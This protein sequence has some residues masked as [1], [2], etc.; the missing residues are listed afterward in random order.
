VILDTTHHSASDPD[1]RLARKSSQTACM[2]AYQA[3]VLVENRHGLVI[4]GMVGHPSGPTEIEQ[5]LV[6]LA[7]QPPRAG[8]TVGGDTE[9]DRRAFVETSRPLGFVSHVAQKRK[10]SSLDAR[11]VRHAAYEVSQ[12]KRKRIEEVFGWTKTIGGLRKLR[13][14]GLANVDWTVTFTLAC[15]TLV[16]L[17]TLL[18][19]TPG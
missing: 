12:R 11:T 8:R 10:R 5:S 16:R 15:D 3:T 6:L 13:H 9:D 4:D 18:A 17:R 1:T 2:L 7:G 19:L 14:R